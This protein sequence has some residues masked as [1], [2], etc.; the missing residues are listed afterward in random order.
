MTPVFPASATSSPSFT[1]TFSTVS[2]PRRQDSL[3]KS[4]RYSH[5]PLQIRSAARWPQ[6]LMSARPWYLSGT[7]WPQRHTS[8][9]FGPQDHV[10]GRVPGAVAVAPGLALVDEQRGGPLGVG[11]AVGVQDAVGVGA[12]EQVVVAHQVLLAGDRHVVAEEVEGPHVAVQEVPAPV[13]VDLRDA[14]PHHAGRAHLEAR[15][16]PEAGQADGIVAAGR[17]AVDVEDLDGVV[18]LGVAGGGVEAVR[19]LQPPERDRLLPVGH[20]GPEGAGHDLLEGA[21]V[22]AAVGKPGVDDV[23]LADVLHPHRPV[24]LPALVPDAEAAADG[25]AAV[26]AVHRPAR[27]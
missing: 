18:H 12:L 1:W 11:P 24:G 7:R 23:G 25:R 13:E 26:G 22:V 8:A 17:V 27:A 3:V 9:S 16:L 6:T 19:G 4:G 5:R 20:A 10:H 2:A 14:V 15:R 21:E